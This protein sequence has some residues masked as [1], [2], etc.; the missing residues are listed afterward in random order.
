MEESGNGEGMLLFGSGVRE[1][2]RGGGRGGVVWELGAR[3]GAGGGSG[4]VVW[5]WG[6]REGAA[7]AHARRP[8]GR[9]PFFAYRGVYW[10]YR[11]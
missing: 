10:C 6:A 9:L 1:R 8:K 11:Y 4:V 2:E 7:V 3:E 5:E